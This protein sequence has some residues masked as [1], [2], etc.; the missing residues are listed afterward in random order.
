MKI[1]GPYDASEKFLDLGRNSF[2]RIYKSRPTLLFWPRLRIKSFWLF[3]RCKFFWW[4][5]NSHAVFGICLCCQSILDES[6]QVFC[7]TLQGSEFDFKLRITF[8]FIFV[9]SCS[10]NWIQIWMFKYPFKVW[11]LNNLFCVLNF[12]Y[13]SAVMVNLISFWVLKLRYWASYI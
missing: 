6:R 10:G 1:C 13:L 2:E 8:P 5:L 3:H 7:I 9:F 4:K 11:I 12:Q